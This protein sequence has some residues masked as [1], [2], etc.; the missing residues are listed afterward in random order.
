MNSLLIGVCIASMILSIIAILVGGVACIF[1]VGWK[2]STHQV[3]LIDPSAATGDS[4][5][6]EFLEVEK[7]MSKGVEHI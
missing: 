7:N 2:N 3:Q 6:K 1:V 4:L 5:A